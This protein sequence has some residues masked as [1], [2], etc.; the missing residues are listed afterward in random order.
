MNSLQTREKEDKSLQTDKERRAKVFG[1]I[2]SA[3]LTLLLVFVIVSIWWYSS[4]VISNKFEDHQQRG[5]FG[6]QF[7]AINSLFSGLAFAGII[8]TILLQSRELSLQRNEL[9]QTREVFDQQKFEATFFQ[10]LRLVQSN[11]SHITFK[12]STTRGNEIVSERVSTGSNAIFNYYKSYYLDRLPIGRSIEH[13][14]HK[15]HSLTFFKKL[16]PTFQT[17]FASIRNSLDFIYLSKIENK[18]FYID[19]LSG[20]LT[21]FDK[22]LICH[23]ILNEEKLMFREKCKDSGLLKGVSDEDLFHDDKHKD[24]Y[25]LTVANNA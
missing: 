16:H 7:G 8:I 14:D 15:Q 24:L 11:L 17:Y 3:I 20:Q 6:D 5:T 18:T 10:L 12:T 2:L 25:E 22:I 21:D 4:E 1:W 13:E 23:Y 19:L 9:K